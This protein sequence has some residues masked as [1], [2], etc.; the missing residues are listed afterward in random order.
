VDVGEHFRTIRAGWWRILIVAMLVAVGTYI[1]RMQAPHQYQAGAV[2]QVV[3]GAALGGVGSTVQTQYV[4]D[5]YSALGKTS[6]VI[7]QA[8]NSQGVPI[9][10][11]EARRR[12]SVETSGLGI[13]FIKAD[14]PSIREA[15]GLAQGVLDALVTQAKNQQISMLK[16]DVTRLT[17]DR[18]RVNADLLRLSPSSR[19]AALARL[20]LTAVSEALAKRNALPAN[21]VSTVAAAASNGLTISPKPFRDAQFAFILALIVAAEL[22]VWR[23]NRAD[24]FSS[25]DESEMMR[26]LGLP[27]L[28]RVPAGT[29]N[30]TLEAIR[31]LRTNLM[32]L[33]GAAKPRTVA[34][35]SANPEAGKTFVAAQ[36]AEAAAAGDEQV[37]L[38]DADLRRPA[39]HDL[40]GLRRAPG[41][42]AV[43]QGADVAGALRR[44]RTGSSLRVLPSG[45]SATDPSGLLGARAFRSVLEQLRS[46]RLV[47]VDTA[48]VSLF[49]DAVAVASQCDATVFVLDMK[50]SRKRAVRTAIETLRRGGANVVG[51]VVNRAAVPRSVLDA[52]A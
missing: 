13:I 42:T 41:L 22:W 47:V 21:Q 25:L 36:L 32:F 26:D 50:S 39:A 27:V 37:V 51:V 49:A 5:T 14:G 29:A 18:A 9:D 28:A 24:R 38:V 8:I 44:V 7:T 30:E 3:S 11:A 23:S 16:T 31:T 6:S 4:T 40:F 2:V 45:S 46:M 12:L 19:E 34:L 52:A 48:P 10:V 43:L 15:V 17:A 1:A 33:S 35:V 20:K